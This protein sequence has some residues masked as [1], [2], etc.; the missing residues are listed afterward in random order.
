MYIFEHIP[1]TAGTTFQFAY[2]MAAFQEGE[3]LITDSLDQELSRLS[4]EQR[5]SLKVIAGHRAECCRPVFPEARWLTL[6]RNPVDRAISVYLHARYHPDAW[7]LIGRETNERNISL[8]RFVEEDIFFRRGGEPGSV[9]NQQTRILLGQAYDPLVLQDRAAVTDLI[10]SRFYLCGCT[11]SFELFLF[12]LHITE[13]WPL[14]LF[15]NRLV[16]KERTTFE[17]SADGL[18]AIEYHNRDDSIVY[19]CVRAEFDRRVAGIWSDATA[20]RYGE[21]LKELETF[22]RNST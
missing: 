13:G 11:E 6:V 16:R 8:V 12:F 15:T 18:A 3:F 5:A 2:I 1:K 9:H 20:A 21:Y 4:P 7:D 19:D 17:P 10:R 14:V 22:R